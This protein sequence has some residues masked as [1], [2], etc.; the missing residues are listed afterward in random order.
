[1]LSIPAILFVATAWSTFVIII[2]VTEHRR[3]SKLEN[4]G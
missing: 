2:A 4:E 1:M 3:L